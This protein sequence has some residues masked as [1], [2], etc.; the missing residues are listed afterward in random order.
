M[1]TSLVLIRLEA[2]RCLSYHRLNPIVTGNDCDSSYQRE[3]GVGV[4]GQ[5]GRSTATP[6]WAGG[7]RSAR[8]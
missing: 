1:A 5:C 8:G 3:P 2:K 4:K 7:T 6:S